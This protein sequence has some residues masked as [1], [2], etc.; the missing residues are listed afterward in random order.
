MWK[1]PCFLGS[2]CPEVC[3]T[4]GPGAVC[5]SGLVL[6]GGSDNLL[7]LLYV[8]EVAPGSV[9]A[10]EGSLRP[11]DLIHFINGAPTHDLTLSESRRLLELSLRNLT[12]K[13]TR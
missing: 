13:A 4:P 2:V 12:L 7:G 1:V 3:L 11:L 6:E 10:G 8:K 9:A 5:S